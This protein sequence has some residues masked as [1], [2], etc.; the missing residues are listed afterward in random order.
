[1]SL[2]KGP[3]LREIRDLESNYKFRAARKDIELLILK[4]IPLLSINS[5]VFIR[6]LIPAFHGYKPVGTSE[7]R[8]FPAPLGH[9]LEAGARKGK[10]LA[11]TLWVL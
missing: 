11:R 9:V 3:D 2:L 5:K 1:M 7:H 10:S 8:G 4:V 6:S